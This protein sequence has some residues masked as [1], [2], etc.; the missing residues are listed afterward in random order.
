MTSGGLT[1]DGNVLEIALIAA[2]LTLVAAM[3]LIGRMAGLR[4]R[5]RA[6]LHRGA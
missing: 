2:I 6:T 1:L 4:W 3:F 5:G